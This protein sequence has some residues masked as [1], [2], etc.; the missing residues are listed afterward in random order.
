MVHLEEGLRSE[1]KVHLRWSPAFAAHADGVKE[2]Y[3]P[4]GIR[5]NAP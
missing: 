2:E 3:T 1:A 5:L 4:G